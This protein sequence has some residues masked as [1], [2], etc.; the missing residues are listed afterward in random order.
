MHINIKIP[1]ELNERRKALNMTWREI[2]EAG[3]KY[4]SLDKPNKNLVNLKPN[5]KVAIK[6]LKEVWDSVQVPST[7]TPKA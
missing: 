4:N 1:D 6:A 7:K 2:I 3:I 5:L